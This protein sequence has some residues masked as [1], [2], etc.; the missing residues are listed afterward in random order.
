MSLKKWGVTGS[1]FHFLISE[2]IAKFQVIKEINEF[3]QVQKNSIIFIF[4]FFS[5]S[6]L[7]GERNLLNKVDRAIDKK[8]GKTSQSCDNDKF[9]Q[10]DNL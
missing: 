5:I 7:L 3:S 10:N 8:K 4:V 6:Q 9:C 2:R 1:D